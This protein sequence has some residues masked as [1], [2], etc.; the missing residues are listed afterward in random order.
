MALMIAGLALFIGIHLVPVVQPLRAR[1]ARR[2]GENGYRGAFSAVAGLGLLLIVAGYVLRPDR[3]QL[4]APWPGARAAA[5]L[6]V[7]LAFVLFAA[8]NM[9]THLRATLKHPML[10]GL[11]LW[12]GVHLLANGDLAGTVLFGAFFAYSIVALASAV[13][14]RAYKRF[15]PAWKFDAMAVA[16]G[17]FAAWLTIF[18]HPWLFGTG[19]VA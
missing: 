7:T 18:V 19:A 4:F 5:P 16:G 2:L 6:L 8:A 13:S 3:V 12:S 14:R 10:L 17:L 11:A 1:L 9:K 15:V